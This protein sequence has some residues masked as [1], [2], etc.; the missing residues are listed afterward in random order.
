MVTMPKRRKAKDNPY[1]LN[2]DEI[3]NTYVV[4][5]K[6]SK[7]EIIKISITDKIYNAFNE[8][9]LK[10]LSQLNKF[11]RH[12]EHSELMEETLYKRAANYQK[13]VEDIVEN[14]ILL[15]ELHDIINILPEIQKRRLIKYY[16]EDKNYKQI[17]REENCSSSAVG[18]SIKIAK[19]KISK[20]LKNIN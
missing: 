14:N 2:Y 7:K 3:N 12:I 11:D 9:E 13:S 18:F 10:D 6:N 15:E 17:A 4:T 19:E 20:N 5:F 16:F 1:I 8:F